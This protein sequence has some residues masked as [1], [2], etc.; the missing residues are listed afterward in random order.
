MAIH[1]PVTPRGGGLT[2]VTSLWEPTQTACGLQF[3]GWVVSTR[4]VNCEGCKSA[5]EDEPAEVP[6]IVLGR[7]RRRS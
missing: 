2:H 7:R 4:A 6:R 1:T 3:R 5:V